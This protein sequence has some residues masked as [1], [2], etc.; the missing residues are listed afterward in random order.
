MPANNL[1]K[2]AKRCFTIRLAV[3]QGILKEGLRVLIEDR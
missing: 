3:D 1:K 2:P